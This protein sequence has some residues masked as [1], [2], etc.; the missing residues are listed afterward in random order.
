MLTKVT[1]SELMD[2]KWEYNPEIESV[3]IEAGTCV[4]P[5]YAFVNCNRLKR[6]I[7]P[8]SI[9]SIGKYAFA[10]SGIEFVTLPQNVISVGEKAF[11]G[12]KD[13][14][15]IDVPKEINIE[16]ALTHCNKKLRVNKY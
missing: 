4:I 9:K 6:V 10:G 14:Y 3:I 5:D 16:N 12:C 13:L 1:S 11:S 7:L 15:C 8:N 2:N